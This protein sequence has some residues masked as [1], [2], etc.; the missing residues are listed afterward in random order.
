M[1]GQQLNAAQV[2]LGEPTLS[3]QLCIAS[4]ECH[5]FP[6]R[7]CLFGVMRDARSFDPGTGVREALFPTPA[8]QDRLEL[9]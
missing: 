9:L 4:R 1:F 3:I 6:I 2:N 7:T 8:E 5:S